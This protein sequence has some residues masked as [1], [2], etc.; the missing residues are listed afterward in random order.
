MSL[1]AATSWLPPERLGAA[2]SAHVERRALR[3]TRDSH[4][5]SAG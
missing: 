5:E 3:G 4:L 1:E 2:T